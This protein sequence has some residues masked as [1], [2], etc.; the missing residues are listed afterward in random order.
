M[1][2]SQEQIVFGYKRRKYKYKASLSL[3]NSYFH[4]TNFNA[5]LNLLFTD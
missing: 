5:F 1:Y 3:S 2:F 4:L